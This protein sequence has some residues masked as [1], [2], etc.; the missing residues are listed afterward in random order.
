MSVECNKVANISGRETGLGYRA[1]GNITCDTNTCPLK[2][3]I[4][5]SQPR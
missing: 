4:T 1:F 2:P 3:V 5:Q